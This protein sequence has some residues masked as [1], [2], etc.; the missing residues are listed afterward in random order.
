MAE[1][2]GVE[3]GGTPGNGGSSEEL[4][5]DEYNAIA[6]ALSA[7]DSTFMNAVRAKDIDGIASMYDGSHPLNPPILYQ[8]TPGYI[9]CSGSI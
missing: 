6:I 1:G 7:R 2:V 9:H 3:S 4:L 8:P 5:P